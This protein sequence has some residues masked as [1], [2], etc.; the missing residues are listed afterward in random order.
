MWVIHH[1]AMS[2]TVE[3]REVIILKSVMW[4][5]HIHIN[6]NRFAGFSSTRGL[7]HPIFKQKTIQP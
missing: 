5:Y 3:E 1:Y 7:S 4:T 2:S 6:S